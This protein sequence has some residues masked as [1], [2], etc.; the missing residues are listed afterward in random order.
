MTWRDQIAIHP[1]ADIFPLLGDDEL[2]ALGEDI[3]RNGL[4]SPIAIIAKKDKPVLLD[5]R[6]R[7]DAME[8]A[9]LRLRINRSMNRWRV[10]AKEKVGTDWK[11]VSV[12]NWRNGS[13]DTIITIARDPIEFITSANINGVKP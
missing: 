3:K 4:T 11:E 1:A 5:G 12:G 8:K 2:L 10:V 9:G 6:N 7:L 13:C